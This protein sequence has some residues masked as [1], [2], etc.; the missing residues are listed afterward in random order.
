VQELAHADAVAALFARL[1][2]DT[3]DRLT[4]STAAM[5]ITA[6]AVRRKVRRVERIADQEHG[7]LQV[8]LFELDSVTVA[9]IHGIARARRD[10]SP[11]FLLVLTDDYQKLDAVLVERKPAPPPTSG[12]ATPRVTVRPHRL[13][14]DRRNP[15]RVELRVL[16][17]F[18]YTESDADA[19]YDKL[20]SAY[21]VAA[22]SEPFFNNRALFADYFLTARLPDLPE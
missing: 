18:T 2:Y 22:W 7:T 17:R 16:R 12:L 20:L 4:Q 11:Q 3:S 9:A 1:G 14:V 10:R 15:G 8:Y 13:T 6:D 5:G 19:Q 21:T